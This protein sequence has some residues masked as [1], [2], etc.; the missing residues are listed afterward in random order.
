MKNANLTLVSKN[1]VFD[2]WL[3]RYRHTSSSCHCDMHFSIYLPP[4]VKYKQLPALYW[5]SGLTCTDVNFFQK[6]GAQ[7][8]AAESGLILI[9]CD[10][11]PRGVHLPGENES[12]DFGTGAGFYLNATQ[13]PWSQHYHMYDYVLNE[14]PKLIES[15]FQVDPQRK[16]IFGHSMGGHG[17]LVLALTNPDTYHSV[18]AFAPIAAP[19]QCPWGQKAFSHYLGDN[20]TLW[21]KYDASCLVSQAKKKLPILIDQGDG[22]EFLVEQLKPEILQNKCS[23]SNYPLTFRMQPGYDHSYY[24]ISSFIGDHI[25]YHAKALSAK[26]D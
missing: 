12:W 3:E 23:K 6:A 13:M 2:G 24:F 16:S 15:H 17:A 7:R 14:L 5:L 9:S 22:D 19:I 21:E 8:Y 26:H 25:N 11:S 1:K 4:Q 18:S 20:K 10:T